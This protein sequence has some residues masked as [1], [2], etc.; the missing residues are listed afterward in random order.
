MRKEMALKIILELVTQIAVWSIVG[1]LIAGAI[2]FGI[3]MVKGLL[4]ALA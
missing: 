3:Y 1:G 2:W 4:G